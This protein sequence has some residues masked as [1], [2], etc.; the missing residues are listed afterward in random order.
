M[1]F[2]VGSKDGIQHTTIRGCP[3][4]ETTA[5]VHTLQ[6]MARAATHSISP[7]RYESLMLDQRG[8]P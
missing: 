8:H 7:H 5:V 3:K 4:V 6:T 2:M 1:A